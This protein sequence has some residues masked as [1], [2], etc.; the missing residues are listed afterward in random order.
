MERDRHEFNAAVASY[1]VIG[2]ALRADLRGARR[3][4]CAGDLYGK[5]IVVTWSASRTIEKLDTGQ[6]V[7]QEVQHKMSFYISSQ[8]RI[9]ARYNPTVSSGSR[10]NSRTFETVGSA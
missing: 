4:R 9:F 5:S 3:R 2:A 6:L 7:Q 10:S 1:S 8:G